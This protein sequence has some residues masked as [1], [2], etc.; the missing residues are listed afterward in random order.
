MN[1]C[2]ISYKDKNSE[3]KTID[4]IVRIL[5][6]EINIQ[7]SV[8]ITKYPTEKGITIIDNRVNQPSVIEFKAVAEDKNIG[9]LYELRSLLRKGVNTFTVVCKSSVYSNMVL[10]SIKE[11]DK[12]DMYDAVEVVLRFVEALVSGYAQIPKRVDDTD[13]ALL[14]VT[15]GLNRLDDFKFNLLTAEEAKKI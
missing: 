11:D 4:S 14:G 1:I 13:T 9:A 5:A 15:L 2:Y 3:N 6:T 7:D 12:S 10:E 8:K